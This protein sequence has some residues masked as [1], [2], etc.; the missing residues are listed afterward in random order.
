MSREQIYMSLRSYYG[1]TEEYLALRG[2]A[3]AAALIEQGVITAQEV[4]HAINKGWNPAL[5]GLDEYIPRI[6]KEGMRPF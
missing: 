3:N 2:L 4:Q 1:E 5:K 6:I